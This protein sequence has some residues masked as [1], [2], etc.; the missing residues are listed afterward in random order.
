VRWLWRWFVELL[1]RWRILATEIDPK[2]G[3]AEVKWISDNKRVSKRRCIYPVQAEQFRKLREESGLSQRAVARL[4]RMPGKSMYVSQVEHGRR[5]ASAAQI[6]S[7][8][9]QASYRRSL[10]TMKVVT[11]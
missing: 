9:E 7:L 8:M 5:L 11:A 1:K 2:T 3:R 4:W 10:R 6:A